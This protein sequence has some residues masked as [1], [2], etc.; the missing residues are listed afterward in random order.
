MKRSLVIVSVAFMLVLSV[1]AAKKKL[2][3][4]IDTSKC[5]Q[6]GKCI[7]ACPAKAI[8]AIKKDGKIVHEI[9][10]S[11]CIKCGLCIENCEFGAIKIIEQT[12]E[13]IKEK[14]K[15]EDEDKGKNDK[16][17]NAQ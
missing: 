2:I 4:V 3:H 11:K 7:E 5:V 15:T 1:F 10:P 16:E 6:C 8:K 12:E 14:K 13:N 17:Q 9:D